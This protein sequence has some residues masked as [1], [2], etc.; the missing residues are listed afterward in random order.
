MSQAI[1]LITQWILRQHPEINHLPMD[2][3]LIENRLIDSLRFMEFIFFL[4]GL[5]GQSIDVSKIQLDDFRSIQT[6]ADKYG[7]TKSENQP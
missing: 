1:P 7:H 4:E 2:I 6:L 3:D 5:S